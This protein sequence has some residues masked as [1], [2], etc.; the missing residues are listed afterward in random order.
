ML[1]GSMKRTFYIPL[2]ASNSFYQITSDRDIFA[3][4]TSV[5]LV[6]QK[7]RLEMKDLIWMVHENPRWLYNVGAPYRYFVIGSDK[8]C[9]HPAPSSATDMLE[10]NAVIIPEAYTLDTDRIKIRNSF[11]WATVHRAV[12]DYWASRGDAKTATKHFFKYLDKLGLQEL[13]PEAHEQIREF[14]TVSEIDRKHEQT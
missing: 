2:T 12:S 7:R 6:N 8:I 10:V 5:W 4:P 3:W 13:Y 1:T 14:A 11:Q 9:I